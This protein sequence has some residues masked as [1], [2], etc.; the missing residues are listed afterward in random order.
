VS[1]PSADPEV[2]H[3]SAFAAIHAETAIL[4]CEEGEQLTCSCVGHSG[5]DEGV[6]GHSHDSP[7]LG[8]CETL[9][10]WQLIDPQRRAPAGR[11]LKMDHCSGYIG[12]VG[13]TEQVAGDRVVE[14]VLVDVCDDRL[15][16][17]RRRVE[18]SGGSPEQASDG[19]GSVV[20]VA[21]V[22]LVVAP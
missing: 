22:V 16:G 19:T 18:R 10:K 6:I 13:G 11:K 2:G 4:E 15:C 9:G 21:V 1:P 20:V 14:A 12:R 7:P 8:H 17:Q 3:N 5:H